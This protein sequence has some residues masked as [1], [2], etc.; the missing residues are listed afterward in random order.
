MSC[1]SCQNVQFKD[2]YSDNVFTWC[3]NCGNYGII[4]AT[5]RALVETKYCP[6]DVLLCYDIGCHGNASD[7]LLGY[8]FHGLHGRVLPFAA[9]A[10][11]A[12]QKVKVIAF[13]GDG[14]TLSEGMGHLIHSIRSNYNFTF[15]LH[16]NSNYGLT[17]GQASSTTPQGIAM[18]ASPD[19]VSADTLNVLELVLGLNPSFAA[20]TFSGDIHHMTNTFKQ[21]INHQGFSI[22]EV[23]QN[24][25]T[26][27]KTTPHEWYQE[28]VYDVSTVENYNSSDLEWAKQIAKDLTE[29]IAMGVLYHDPDRADFYHRQK[30]RENVHTELVDEVK[31]FDVSGLL[32]NFK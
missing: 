14:G 32:K 5:K 3:T 18:N 25:P 9:G 19:G 26:Y 16:N 6:K 29:K 23:L 20:R 4:A 27:N 24:C 8:R 28:R 13:G 10:A 21:A 15:I 12:N 31:E 30:N 7:K 1:N 17:T 11:L 2:Y 22:V